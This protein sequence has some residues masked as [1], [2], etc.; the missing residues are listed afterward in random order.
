MT[1]PTCTNGAA[2]IG[3]SARARMR[4]T[5]LVR[6]ASSALAPNAPRL[7]PPRPR[8]LKLARVARRP[9][10]A[11]HAARRCCARC[12]RRSPRSPRLPAHCPTPATRRQPPPPSAALHPSRTRRCLPRPSQRWSTWPKTLCTPSARLCALRRLAFALP[13]PTLH[14]LNHASHDRA[15]R[16]RAPG[17]DA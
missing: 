5:R 13:T 11:V 16:L 9:C 15:R 2:S 12:L 6:C 14:A 7:E 4:P 17:D 10:H 1:R 3:V 8:T